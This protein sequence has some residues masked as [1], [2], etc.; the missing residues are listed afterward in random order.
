[1][2]ATS[3][4]N[5]NAWYRSIAVIY[6]R[7]RYVTAILSIFAGFALLVAGC[8]TMTLSGNPS[9][10]G[11]IAGVI[12]T[13]TG[14]AGVVSIQKTNKREFNWLYIAAGVVTTI[15][16]A[17]VVIIL[18]LE[19][20]EV[21]TFC[22]KLKAEGEIK[23]KLASGVTNAMDPSNLSSN[24]NLLTSFGFSVSC[25]TEDLAVNLYYVQMMLTAFEFEVA[26]LGVIL[27]SVACSLGGVADQ[28]QENVAMV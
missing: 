4:S 8:I 13:L 19:L 28:Y 22:G 1:M 24:S 25:E 18:M 10:M 5:H 20:V 6:S 16:S 7:S 12:V 27:A 2:V 15:F 17:V 11:L 3:E 21:L 26:V 14:I 9:P 23:D